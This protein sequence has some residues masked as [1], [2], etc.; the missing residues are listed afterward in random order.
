MHTAQVPD[1]GESNNNNIIDYYRCKLSA[2]AAAFLSFLAR[3]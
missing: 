3:G 1:S 2:S